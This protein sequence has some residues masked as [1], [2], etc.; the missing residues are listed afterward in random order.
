MCN[1]WIPKLYIIVLAQ[2][3]G[4][5]VDNLDTLCEKFITLRM[6]IFTFGH[7]T[8]FGCECPF[9]TGQSSKL[10]EKTSRMFSPKCQVVSTTFAT[11]E[12]I[13]I[14]MKKVFF[15]AKRYFVKN[16]AW[17]VNKKWNNHP[18]V[19]ERWRMSCLIYGTIV[20][21]LKPIDLLK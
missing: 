21:N 20:M 6:S 2:T 11:H 19:V 16:W 13:R 18:N 8:R 7:L 10:D 5:K 9:E 3:R 4:I 17:T 1:D 15:V 12:I 14:F